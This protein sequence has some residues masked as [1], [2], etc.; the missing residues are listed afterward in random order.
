MDRFKFIQ[1]LRQGGQS[2]ELFQLGHSGCDFV[3]R[4]GVAGSPIF[5]GFERHDL[6]NVLGNWQ[7]ECPGRVQNIALRLPQELQ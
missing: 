5:A 6:S 4:V 3:T 7:S 1:D 2:K